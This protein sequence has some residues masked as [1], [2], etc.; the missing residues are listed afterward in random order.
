[1][2]LHPNADSGMPLPV[3]AFD[4]SSPLTCLTPS[5][6]FRLFITCNFHQRERATASLLPPCS[7]RRH[8]CPHGSTVACIYYC[9]GFVGHRSHVSSIA[10]QLSPA[11]PLESPLRPHQLARIHPLPAV[12]LIEIG[13]APLSCSWPFPYRAIPQLREIPPVPSVSLYNRPAC[14]V[15]HT[16]LALGENH[17]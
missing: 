2:L 15:N 8:T 3:S 5:V 14:P 17:L 13:R 11:P 6:R 9:R 4:Q 1:M 12:G 16:A 7:G 10:E